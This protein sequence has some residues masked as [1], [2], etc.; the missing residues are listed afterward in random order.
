MKKSTERF[1]CFYCGIVLKEHNLEDDHF[2]C[3]FNVGGSTVVLACSVCHKLKHLSCDEQA[4]EFMSTVIA[5]WNTRLGSFSLKFMTQILDKNFELM[6]DDV[7]VSRFI[8][9]NFTVETPR[10][11]KIYFAKL[12]Y[13]MCTGYSKEG[14][15]KFFTIRYDNKGLWKIRI[16]DQMYNHAE[17]RINRANRG[18]NNNATSQ[19]DR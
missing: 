9:E 10:E 19:T 6:G 15:T 2:P 14:P 1:S 4:P 5:D 3:P 16:G 18:R 12:L 7:A 8:T 17:A 13:L 11:A